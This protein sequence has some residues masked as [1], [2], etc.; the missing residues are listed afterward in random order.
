MAKTTKKEELSTLDVVL[1][2]AIG[3]I[4]II[5]GTVLVI[6]SLIK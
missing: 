1:I 4:S 5:G 6:L 2:Y 3:F